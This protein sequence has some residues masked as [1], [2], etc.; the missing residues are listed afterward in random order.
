[1]GQQ[2]GKRVVVNKSKWKTAA[3]QNGTAKRDTGSGKKF[4]KEKGGKTK[5]DSKAGN[6]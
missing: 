1:M 6:G 5:W 2:I 3:K 4:G